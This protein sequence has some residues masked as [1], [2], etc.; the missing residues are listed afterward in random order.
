MKRVI[1]LLIGTVMVLCFMACSPGGGL[2]EIGFEDEEEVIEYFVEKL[3]D[4]DIDGALRVSAHNLMAENFNYKKYIKMLNFVPNLYINSSSEYDLGIEVNKMRNE[5]A[6][7]NSINIMV[8][9]FNTQCEM[10]DVI[11]QNRLKYDDVDFDDLNE[12]FNPSV[13]E[14]I[15]IH[16]ITTPENAYNENFE[17]MMKET[18]EIYGGYDRTIRTVIYKYDGD[19]YEAEMVLI[20]YDDLWYI[21]SVGKGDI[22]SPLGD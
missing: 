18:A 14:E 8:F 12:Y 22:I 1:G 17:E 15:T 11:N 13:L 6:V 4:V 21:E 10:F 16:E 19:Y 2:K 20:Q 5:L 9:Q 3:N 7:R